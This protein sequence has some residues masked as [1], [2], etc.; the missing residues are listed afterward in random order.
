[1][2]A[3]LVVLIGLDPPESN[4][5]LRRCA[6]RL[7]AYPMLPRV[8]LRAE[9]L[10]LG[11][12]GVWDCP[13]GKVV[14]HGIFADDLPAV[15]VLALCGGPCLPS[16]HGVLDTRPRIANQARC[17]RVPR[18]AGL[19]RSYADAGTMVTA[20]GSRVA[21][22]GEWHCGEGKSRFDG[23]WAASEPTLIEPFLDGEGVRVTAI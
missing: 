3:E 11:R 23:A 13:V 10:F 5:P 6:A 14:S 8:Q 18:F 16:A 15:T 17:R 2:P 21:K 4:D 1:M 19:P 12:G 22:W 9:E 20:V 7:V